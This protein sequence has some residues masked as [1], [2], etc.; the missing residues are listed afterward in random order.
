MQP[1]RVEQHLGRFEPL[2]THFDDA[3]IGQSVLLYQHRLRKE[4]KK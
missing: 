3:T 2:A 1:T 4:R